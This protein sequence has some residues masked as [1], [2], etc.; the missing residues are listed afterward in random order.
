ME[1]LNIEK[2]L[3]GLLK[4]VQR[5]FSMDQLKNTHEGDQQ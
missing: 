1:I 3:K 2:I 4:K 5:R